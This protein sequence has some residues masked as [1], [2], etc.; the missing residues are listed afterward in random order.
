MA[1]D[2]ND[3]VD[4][5][6]IVRFSNFSMNEVE[7]AAFRTVSG[8]DGCVRCYHGMQTEESSNGLWVQDWQSLAHHA[9]FQ[10]SE[11]YVP[12]VAGVSAFAQAVDAILHVPLRP[13]PAALAFTAPLTEVVTATLRPTST[14]DEFEETLA[15]ALASI[16]GLARCSYG[17]TLE[18]DKQV[19]LVNGWDSMDARHTVLS[20]ETAQELF[21]RLHGLANFDV[22][23]YALS[24]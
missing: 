12:F 8:L 14:L 3:I 17:T 16:P 10:A 5:T 9:A 11:I 20:S 13:Y 2:T 1:D 19:V 7:A 24:S 6:E 18:N 4:V 15:G 21:G 22:K 23:Y